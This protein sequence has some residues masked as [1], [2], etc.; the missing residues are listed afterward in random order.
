MSSHGQPTPEAARVSVVA[1]PSVGAVRA[2]E[3]VRADQRLGWLRFTPDGTTLRMEGSI[4]ARFR[5]A[6]VATAAVRLACQ[7]VGARPAGDVART[8]EARVPADWGAAQ[9]V[10]EA[11]GFTCDDV[12]ADPLSFVRPLVEGVPVTR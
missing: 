3:V 4:D 12:T 11:N 10:L 7:V 5:G 6:G 1:G 8:V 2:F 9:R